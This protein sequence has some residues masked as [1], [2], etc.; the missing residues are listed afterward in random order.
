MVVS[1][2]D[3]RTGNRCGPDLRLRSEVYAIAW[4]S[5]AEHIVTRTRDGILRKW[6]NVFESAT[7][8]AER[9]DC[10]AYWSYSSWPE[11]SQDGWLEFS[12]DDKLIVSYSVFESKLWN[13]SDLSLVRAFHPMGHRVS[14]IE[15]V[16]FPEHNLN[17]R[18]FDA[19]F[20]P[21]SGNTFVAWTDQGGVKILDADT[22][23]E[24]T[25]LPY[26][27]VEAT[28]FTPDG[29]Y[30]LLVL[31]SNVVVLWDVASGY[32]IDELKLD[33]DSEYVGFAKISRSCHV[34]SLEF[35]SGSACIVHLSSEIY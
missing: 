10:N 27:D 21:P 35:G 19:V 7:I 24:K 29:N 28:R 13:A 9:K 18:M 17:H 22:F 1:F 3:A 11:F 16:T 34:L 30:L 33:L 2:L 12:P 15:N 23:E 5:T 14:N 26:G 32:T 31:R 20:D 8:V 6:S 4:S 25:S